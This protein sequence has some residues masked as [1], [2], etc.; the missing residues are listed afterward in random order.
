MQG[1][2]SEHANDSILILMILKKKKK[3]LP[4]KAT[5]VCLGLYSPA[6]NLTEEY[7]SIFWYKLPQK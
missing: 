3:K 6:F 4:E 2:H 1:V 5:A 7:W